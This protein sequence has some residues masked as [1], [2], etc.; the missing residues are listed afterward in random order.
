MAETLEIGILHLL[1]KLLADALVFFRTLQSAGAVSTGTLQTFPNGR[2]HFLIF[3][4]TNSHVN[5]SFPVYYI[6]LVKAL[7]KSLPTRLFWLDKPGALC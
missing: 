4:Q 3:I 7:T 1:P 5:T 2:Y 6:T